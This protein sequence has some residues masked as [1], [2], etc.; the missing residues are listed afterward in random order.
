MAW[1]YL[2]ADL[3]TGDVIT[4]LPL[5]GVSLGY[6]LSGAGRWSATVPMNDSRIRALDPLTATQPGKTM[7]CADRDGELMFCGPVWTRRRKP[8]GGLALQG[9]DPWS[10]TA[11]IFVQ[12]SLFDDED[13]ISEIVN[14]LMSEWL[15]AAGAPAWLGRTTPASGV[16]R[17]RRYYGYEFKPLAEAVEQLSQVIDG[18]DFRMSYAWAGAAP[19]ASVDFA[20]PRIGLSAAVDDV[21]VFD[22]PGNVVDYD[23]SEDATRQATEMTAIGA[24]EG[25]DMLRT[26][27]LDGGL[28]GAGWP[29]LAASRAYKDVRVIATLF[30]HVDADLAAARLPVTVP[31]LTV[32]ERSADPIIGV[33]AVGDDCRLILA[34]DEFPDPVDVYA[35]ILALDVRPDEGGQD[36]I[37]VTLGEVDTEEGS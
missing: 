16:L 24:G 10:W 23:W 34:G 21:P 12:D 15:I 29:R 9:G 3:V 4:E 19:S 11:R 37:K 33:A 31:A 14:E 5:T 32:L 6:V 13:Q 22:M 26:T 1:S 35:R 25:D 17:D 7:L 36:E 28:L 20:Y 30:E 27:V 8:G 2:F 18:F